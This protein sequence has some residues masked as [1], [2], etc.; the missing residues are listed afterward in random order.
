MLFVFGMICGGLGIAVT[1]AV[2]GG[3]SR[4]DLEMR[5]HEADHRA[6]H[7]AAEANRY[8]DE[9]VGL[10]QRLA[11]YEPGDVISD[12]TRRAMNRWGAR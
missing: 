3:M 12:A 5:L 8:A 7:W 2:L 6:D 9:L 10:R 11:A 4:A 1:L